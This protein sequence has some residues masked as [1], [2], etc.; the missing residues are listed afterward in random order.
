[1]LRIII[2][3]FLLSSGYAWG[4]TYL[5][6][7]Q[8]DIKTVTGPAISGKNSLYFTI[9]S[10]IYVHD[11]YPLESSYVPNGNVVHYTLGDP[12][13]KPIL[14]L[15][16]ENIQRYKEE[17]QARKTMFLF[18]EPI[19]EIDWEIDR[20]TVAGDGI[21]LQK[22]NGW[23]GNRHYVVWFS[24]DIPFPYGPYRLGGLPGL[25]IK[26]KSDDGIVSFSL[27]GF[28]KLEKEERPA[29]L[30]NLGEAVPITIE[31]FRQY[32]IKDLLRVEAKSTTDLTM[33]NR[34]PHENYTIEKGRWTILSEYKIKRGN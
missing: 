2:L 33:T 23:Y 28:G 16:R 26:A 17:Y 13:G 20:E 14:T 10:A 8:A 29:N 3:L 18:E 4:Q 9:D 7:Y 22:A 19:A 15:R 24:P 32:V 34:D 12:N 11:N 5:A 30:F 27:T 31:K 6:T 25:I 1:M 21:S